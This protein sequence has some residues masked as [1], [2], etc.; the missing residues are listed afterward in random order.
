MPKFVSYLFLFRYL[1]HESLEKYGSIM[2]DRPLQKALEYGVQSIGEEFM[3]VDSKSAMS[4]RSSSGGGAESFSN[5]W[6]PSDMSDDQ[7]S[8]CSV[9]AALS[10]SNAELVVPR[11]TLQTEHPSP[12]QDIGFLRI[13]VCG[14]S[15]NKRTTLPLDL[16]FVVLLVYI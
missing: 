13:I 15:G 3:P 8:S 12:A 16:L 2:V 14:D 10:E 5:R 11:V 7:K 1:L 9:P 6:A 4:S